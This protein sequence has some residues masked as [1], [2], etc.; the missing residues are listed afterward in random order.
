[1][2][3]S[4]SNRLLATKEGFLNKNNMSIEFGPKANKLMN[5]GGGVE[6]TH[7]V[8]ETAQPRGTPTRG[9]RRRGWKMGWHGEL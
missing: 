6:T 8:R 1:M 7:I 4:M 2:K 5:T 3:F 9:I